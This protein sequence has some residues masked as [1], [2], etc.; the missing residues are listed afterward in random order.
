[1]HLACQPTICF[2]SFYPVLLP[3][4]IERGVSLT[5][6]VAGFSISQWAFWVSGSFVTTNV[7][8]TC[9]ALP[10]LELAICLPEFF[11]A[12]FLAT[13]AAPNL[14]EDTVGAEDNLRPSA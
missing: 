2:V 10:E 3:Q 8:I 7:C 12:R 14:W 5:P 9:P 1:M 4:L 13:V 6:C 11:F